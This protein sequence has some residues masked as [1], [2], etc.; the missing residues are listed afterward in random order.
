MLRMLRIPEVALTSLKRLPP[1]LRK[2]WLYSLSAQGSAT[3]AA[4]DTQSNVSV[5]KMSSRPSPLRSAMAQEGE[6]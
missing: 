2:S 5:T 3:I 1:W 6:V 4:L